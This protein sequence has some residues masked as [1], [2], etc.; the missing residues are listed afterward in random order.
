M[1]NLAFRLSALLQNMDENYDNPLFKQSMFDVLATTIRK[2]D[3]IVKRFRDHQ[4]QVVIKLR[5]DVNQILRELMEGLRARKIRNLAIQ[6]TLDELPPI[7]ADAFYLHSAFHSILENAIEAMPQGGT[8]AVKTKLIR[9]GK[10]QRIYVEFSDS[11]VGMTQAFMETKL[12]NPFTTTKEQGLGL[13][14][15]TSQQIIALHQGK[16]EA[17]S[18]PG[19]GSMF[20]IILPVDDDAS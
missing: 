9:R 17:E 15:F 16:I 3:S 7:W 8:L 14:L 10:K 1:K 2:M 5:V 18:T 4:Q 19:E 20:R 13:G 6:I 12:F 11:G